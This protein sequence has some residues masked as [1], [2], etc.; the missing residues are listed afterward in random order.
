MTLTLEEKNQQSSGRANPTRVPAP[1]AGATLAGTT[2]I[3]PPPPGWASV[4]CWP[5]EWSAGRRHPPGRRVACLNAKGTEL[6]ELQ[7]KEQ[8]ETA[9]NL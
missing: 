8:L 2:L 3:P 6:L 4:A 7:R 9:R 1:H 5:A